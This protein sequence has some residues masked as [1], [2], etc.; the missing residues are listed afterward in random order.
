MILQSAHNAIA[1]IFK[2]PQFYAPTNTS[3]KSIHA[4]IDIH[5]GAKPTLQSA[6]NANIK[7]LIRMN[8]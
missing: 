6:M 4:L 3:A 2:P 5:A 8:K 1:P 7:S